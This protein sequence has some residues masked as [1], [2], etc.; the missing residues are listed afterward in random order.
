MVGTNWQTLPLQPRFPSPQGFVY[1]DRGLQPR[2]GVV[3]TEPH[4][5][6]RSSNRSMNASSRAGKTRLV[7]SP[8]PTR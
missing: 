6:A 3:S 2:A 5:P 1:V 7:T 8:K 4:Y